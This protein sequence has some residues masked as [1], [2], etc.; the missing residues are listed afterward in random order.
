MEELDDKCASLRSEIAA[1]EARLAKLKRELQE[2]EE[3]ARVSRSTNNAQPATSGPRP[4][5]K[6]PLLKEE[7]R[8]YG[9]QMIVPQVGLQGEPPTSELSDSRT[10][11]TVA[12]HIQDNSNSEKRRS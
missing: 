3:S 4:E 10:Q 5:R 7:Y 11:L 12:F 8:R 1:T 2:A 9:R 6:W